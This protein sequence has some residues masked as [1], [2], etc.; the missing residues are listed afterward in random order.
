[1]YMG[2]LFWLLIKWTVTLGI[3]TS[4]CQ[5][6]CDFRW[7]CD[8]VHMLSGKWTRYSLDIR[9]DRPIH[10]AIEKKDRA[11]SFLVKVAAFR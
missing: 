11:V 1:M 8:I 9:Y 6:V 5:D 10:N 7:C 4:N 3:H 2:D